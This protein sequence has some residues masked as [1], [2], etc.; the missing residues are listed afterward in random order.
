MSDL[1]EIRY[2][3][4]ADG[5]YLAYQVLGEG[6]LDLLVP[7][8]GSYI[9]IDMRDEE[10]RWCRFERRLGSFSRLIRFDPRG[11]GLSDP[12]PTT[13]PP[14]IEDVRQRRRGRARRGGI[15][16]SGHLRAGARRAGGDPVGRDPPGAG[17][18]GGVGSRVRPSHA[19][20]RLS[21]GRPA[22]DFD[23]FVNDVLRVEGVTQ[24]VDD[25]ALL[26]PSLADD[27]IFRRCWQRAGRA[28][29]SPAVARAHYQIARNSDLRAVLRTITAPTLV[30]HRKDNRYYPPPLGRYLAANIPGA[31]YVELDGAD[32]FL[33]AGD[34]GPMLDT[35]E[36]FL[37]GTLGRGEPDR[38]LATV[39]FTDI[40]G[41]TARAAE[42]GDHRWRGLLDAHDHLVRRQLE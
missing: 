28:G 3:R 18:G 19:G 35:I 37:T 1:A 4:T 10:P 6:T 7:S 40:V 17:P 11:V 20:P 15:T 33:W 32:H 34:A 26:L 9:S 38:L 36:E 12:V 29:A 5:T 30:M 25:V 2:A 27:A 13:A 42:I 14:S 41:S 21:R 31:R 22:E 8:G 24:P 39:M 23:D 16:S